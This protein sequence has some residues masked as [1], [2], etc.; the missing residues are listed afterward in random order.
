MEN[1]KESKRRRTILLILLIGFIYL[2]FH[3]SYSSYESEADGVV[4]PNA[5]KWHIQINGNDVSN[6]PTQVISVDDVN[7]NATHT[8]SGKIG[9]GSTGTVELELDC[10]GTE[11]SVDYEFYFR[12]SSVDSNLILTVTNVTSTTSSTRVSNN[13]YTGRLSLT[14]INNNVKPVIT[15]YLSW[16]NDDTINDLDRD[17]DDDSNFLLIDFN[18]TQYK[19]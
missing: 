15:V 7:W 2:F 17:I 12:D 6:S 16:V 1:S 5:S 19:G 8:R 3:V 14:E 9:P 10:T 4:N 11:V 13:R 18:A